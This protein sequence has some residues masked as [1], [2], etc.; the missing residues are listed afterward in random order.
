M[1]TNKLLLIDHRHSG[2]IISVILPES[3]AARKRQKKKQ[4]YKQSTVLPTAKYQMSH[5]VINENLI[6]KQDHMKTKRCCQKKK[7]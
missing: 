3:V 7:L 6:I 2:R 1:W 5:Y 4:R